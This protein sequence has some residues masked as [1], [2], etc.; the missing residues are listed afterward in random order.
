MLINTSLASAVGY[1]SSKYGFDPSSKLSLH[2]VLFS[3][4]ILLACISHL[5]FNVNS[6]YPSV[7]TTPPSFVLAEKFEALLTHRRI[8]HVDALN[9]RLIPA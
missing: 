3:L 6:S 9:Q 4:W 8:C 2:R 1:S 7:P 5:D